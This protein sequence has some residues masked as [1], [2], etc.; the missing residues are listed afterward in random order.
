MRQFS[1]KLW[2][3]YQRPIINLYD[4]PALIDTGASI[5]MLS[6]NKFALHNKFRA[7]LLRADTEISGI[8][9]AAHGD[10]YALPDFFIGEMHFTRLEIFV[11]RFQS[12]QYPFLLSA[13]LFYGTSYEIDTI[14]NQFIV[15]LPDDLPFEREFRILSLENALYPQ[16]GVVTAGDGR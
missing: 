13:T 7:K 16:V 2:E 6:T 1:I 3:D 12:L 11:P 9:G 10:I 15:K 5:P 14:N 8:G 4:H